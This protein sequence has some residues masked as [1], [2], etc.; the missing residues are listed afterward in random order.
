MSHVREAK[1]LCRTTVNFFSLLA[2]THETGSRRTTGITADLLSL[3]TRLAHYLK[4]L[5]RI[6]LTGALKLERE[7]ADR[8]ALA[9]FLDRLSLLARDGGDP[10]ARRRRLLKQRAQAD[11]TG[12]S[13]PEDQSIVKGSKSAFSFDRQNYGYKSLFL[14]DG[15]SL[16]RGEIGPAE[17]PLDLCVACAK[18]VEEDC[19]RLGTYPHWHSH[20]VQ[21]TTCGRA[22][23]LYL[24]EEKK[25]SPDDAKSIRSS[26]ARKPRPDVDAFVFLARRTD[27]PATNAIVA[28]VPQAI[29]CLDHAVASSQPGFETV[30]RLEQFSFLLNAALRRLYSHLRAQGV[31]AAVPGES[32]LLALS[33]AA[34]MAD[35]RPFVFDFS[36]E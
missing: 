25:T 28:G 24:K 29:F 34:Q 17:A 26:P 6:S 10:G 16:L 7:H 21:C 8:S 22:A 15:E 14:A 9:G 23:A 4:I 32:L 1:L 18:P 12:S 13:P 33:C 31:V 2:H 20:C 11:S 27:Q 19:V 3:V 35:C 30:T 5:I 36:C